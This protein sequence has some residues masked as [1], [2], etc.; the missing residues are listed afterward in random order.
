M[1]KVA[2]GCGPEDVSKLP[3]AV[4]W[5][6]SGT[7]LWCEPSIFSIGLESANQMD[8]LLIK[9]AERFLKLVER[10]GGFVSSCMVAQL[11]EI[12]EADVRNRA[13]R[14]ALIARRTASG[15]LSFPRFQFDE[16][17]GQVLAGVG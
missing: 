7:L 2:S 15:E 4:N 9:G 13:Q 10:A 17:K 16:R 8:D 11:L 1:T 12:S 14:N 3:K 6:K 5:S